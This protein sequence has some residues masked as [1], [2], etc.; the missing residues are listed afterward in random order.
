MTS[1][2]AAPTPR[3]QWSAEQEAA[4]RKVT[5]WLL[6]PK[7]QQVFKLFGPAGTGKTTM[8][9]QVARQTV[10]TTV[11]AAYTGKAASVMV[12]KGCSGATTLHSAMYR[13]VADESGRVRY[14]INPDSPIHSARLIIVDE[15]SMVDEALGKELLSFNRLVLVLGDPY[16]LPPISGAGFF[17]RGKPD[18]LLEQIHRQAV[19]DPILMLASQVRERKS[20][21]LGR[22]G[23]TK[24]IPAIDLTLADIE[25]ADQILVGRNTTRRRINTRL[26]QIQGFDDPNPLPGDKIVCLRNNR[27]NA[28][29]NGGIWRVTRRDGPDEHG[30]LRLHIR[31]E[32]DGRGL[33]VRT[34]ADFFGQAPEQALDVHRGLDAFYFGYALTVHKAQGSQWN[35]VILFDESDA[36]SDL[37]SRWLYTGITR[38]ARELTVVTT[39]SLSNEPRPVPKLPASWR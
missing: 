24:V 1:L 5:S 34:H 3:A 33:E 14:E 16:Q 10:G 25:K 32:D 11:F 21:K 19:N 22:Y 2:H 4:L 6:A 23:R 28:L 26:R 13:P 12:A 30:R 38:A 18:V 29:F 27:R 39:R 36:F 9:R 8:A 37:R 17:I 7:D 35:S 20:L 31:H 15:I